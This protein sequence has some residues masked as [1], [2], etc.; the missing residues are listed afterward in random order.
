MQDQEISSSRT[1]QK[2]KFAISI[3]LK[4]VNLCDSKAAE[5]A[6][7]QIPATE[8]PVFYTATTDRVTPEL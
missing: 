2:Q 1:I 3:A 7:T 8:Q 5:N 4:G 6:I